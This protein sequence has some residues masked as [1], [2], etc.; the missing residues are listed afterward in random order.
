MDIH[1]LLIH[2]LTH[3]HFLNVRGL[4]V[5]LTFEVKSATKC[6]Q[7]TIETVRLLLWVPAL[8]AGYYSGC[9]AGYY[10]GCRLL[11]WVPFQL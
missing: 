2:V 6:L 7:L 11:L 10:S 8:G 5:I 3:S 1:Y 4:E 9:R